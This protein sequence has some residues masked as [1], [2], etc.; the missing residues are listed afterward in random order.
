MM[1]TGDIAA[2]FRAIMEGFE[3]TASGREAPHARERT[4]VTTVPS[5]MRLPAVAPE[6]P[7]RLEGAAAVGA[8]GE[9]EAEA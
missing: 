1:S 7:S 2:L 9:E 5:S 4:R 3:A 8:A 6:A